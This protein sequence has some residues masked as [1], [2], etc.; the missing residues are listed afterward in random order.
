MGWFEFQILNETSQRNLQSIINNDLK[1][2][3]SP[4]ETG[5]EI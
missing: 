4:S 5:Y 3:S 1:Q 2:K